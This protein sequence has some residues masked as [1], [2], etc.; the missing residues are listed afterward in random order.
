M[1]QRIDDSPSELEPLTLIQVIGSVFAA[2]LGVQSRQ[3]K[4]RDFTRGRALHFFIAGALATLIFLAGL[5]TVVN[6][7]VAG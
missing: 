1:L 7:V 5:I 4:V 6:L 3:N 2:A